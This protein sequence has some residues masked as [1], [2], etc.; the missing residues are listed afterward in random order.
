MVC[1]STFG[2]CLVQSTVSVRRK[3]QQRGECESL[4]SPQSHQRTNERTKRKKESLQRT[5]V[6]L[7]SSFT[8]LLQ[9]VQSFLFKFALPCFLLLENCHCVRKKQ[10]AV[11]SIR[12]S[13]TEQ[14]EEGE[15]CTKANNK[16]MKM[17]VHL[18]SNTVSCVCSRSFSASA[19]LRDT[20]TKNQ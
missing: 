4:S 2:I 7:G 5:L 18:V 6:E 15:G 20:S 17:A 16:R 19:A 11:V 14:E 9:R 12:S 13:T 8:E 1:A 10:E 3:Q